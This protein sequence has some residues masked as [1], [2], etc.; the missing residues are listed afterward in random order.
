MEI[1]TSEVA[2]TETQIRWAS[3]KKEQPISQVDT[4]NINH[5]LRISQ[6]S[7]WEEGEIYVNCIQYNSFWE[8]LQHSQ[9]TSVC[10]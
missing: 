1:N 6:S 10:K 2:D 4:R 7:L 5:K 3:F 8:Q 9:N